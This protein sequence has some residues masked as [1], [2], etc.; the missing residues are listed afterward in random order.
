M[1]AA[2]AH[3]HA[4]AAKRAALAAAAVAVLLCFAPRIVS[5]QTAP[6]PG[7]RDQ[8]SLAEQSLPLRTALHHDPTLD[9][10]LQ[11]LV[12]LYRHRDRVDDLLALYAQ[13]LDRWPQDQA[14]RTVYLRLLLAT[15]DPSALATARQAVEAN[16]EHAFF[17]YLLY[18]AL[19]NGG[20]EG[21]LDH[22]DQ[23]IKLSDDPA[24]RQRWI[25]AFLPLAEAEGRTEQIKRHLKTLAAHAGDDPLAR[26]DAARSMMSLDQHE[27]A[28]ETLVAT[29]E[30]P[31]PAEASVELAM[32]TARAEAELGQ[33]QAAAARLDG[34]LER[35]SSDYWRR[36]QIVRQR[37]G[38]IETEAER[39]QMI[40][41]AEQRVANSPGDVSAVLSLVDMLAGFDRHRSA[42]ARLREAGERMPQS[43]ALEHATLELLDRMRNEPARVEFLKNRLERE[44]DRRSLRL[45]LARSLY[46][47]GRDKE[48]LE[49]VDRAVAGLDAGER[50][51]R[52]LQT[53][54]FLR[55]SALVEPSAALFQRAV[56]LRP[57][58]LDV[59]RELAE[60]HLAMDQRGEVG[61]LFAEAAAPEAAIENVLDLADFLI[62]QGFLAEARSLIEPRLD[63]LPTH[64]DLRLLMLRVHGELAA[65]G[66]GVDL[67][68]RSRQLTD[69]T[70]RYRRW[71]EAAVAFHGNFDTVATFLKNEGERLRERPADWGDAAVQ[72]RLAYV[73]VAK[74]NGQQPA[75]RRLLQA[76]LEQQ[77]PEAV[78]KRF[79]RELLTLL[80]DREDRAELQRLLAELAEQ[81]ASVRDEVNARLAVMHAQQNRLHLAQPLLQDIDPANIRDLSLLR[82]L[83][84]VCQRLGLDDQL[85]P[86]MERMVELN[87][88]SRP[89]WEQ[90]LEALAMR[91]DESRF[92]AA[93]R[94]LSMGI[95][96]MPLNTGTK[97]RLRMHLLSSY[98]RSIGRLEQ[99][100]DP[101]AWHE[102]LGLIASA[103]RIVHDPRELTWI[104]WMRAS[105]L[106]RLG[107]EDARDEAL[108]E[109]D[110][111]ARSAAGQDQQNPAAGGDTT[112]D[113]ASVGA[114]SEPSS[115]ID[116][117]F[118]DGMRVSLAEAKRVL[119]APF[120][121]TDAF[122]ADRQGPA[123]ASGE[124][125]QRWAFQ[126]PGVGITAV[127]RGV[128]DDL[129]L[130]DETGGLW[131]VDRVTGKLRWR[132]LEALPA[133]A[134][135]S[136]RQQSNI[137][138][139]AV[140]PLRAPGDRLVASD[141]KQIVC[142]SLPERG[143]VWRSPLAITA[144]DNNEAGGPVAL[145]I[146]GAAVLAYEAAADRL[147]WFDLDTGKLLDTL[148]LWED[149][150]PGTPPHN[151]SLQPRYAELQRH[152]DRLLVLGP[153]IAIVDLPSREVAWRFDP[154]GVARFPIQLKA[155]KD[156]DT[157]AAG[158]T[159]PASQ[160]SFAAP[161]ATARVTTSGM[162]LQRM[163]RHP[164]GVTV[165][166]SARAAGNAAVRYVDYHQSHQHSRSHHPSR[167]NAFVLSSPV[168]TW[169][170]QADSDHGATAALLADR[171]VLL[172]Q[173]GTI[174][175]SYRNPL[176][177][178]Q[179]NTG[180][181]LLGVSGSQ[182]VL[183]SA[184]H[185]HRFD[186]RTLV[187]RQASI[188]DLGP[189]HDGCID[190]PVT[191]AAG[192]NGVAA[193]NTVTGK[194]LWSHRWPGAGEGD[195]GPG[196]ANHASAQ[197]HQA[198]YL[199]TM[200]VRRDANTHQP[201]GVH[202]V[203]ARP[204]DGVLYVMRRPDELVAIE[205]V[206]R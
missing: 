94:K 111:I 163:Q 176:G 60:V 16:P 12:K 83:H 122:P 1:N 101:A 96:K 76:A 197:P 77:P 186:T 135:S 32:I 199:P 181:T 142:L 148:P 95:E 195:H 164:S 129:V 174:S 37:L 128:D 81:D 169:M 86:L 112:G 9:A 157:S 124:V 206:T 8:P 59:K 188:Q 170:Q 147:A 19:E 168:V 34:L 165:V 21:A 134:G 23:A 151:G 41:R 100:D 177:A 28:L 119:T 80:E 27:L 153:T 2:T 85:L 65:S 51:E 158:A 113:A 127:F 61:E 193:I 166:H 46:L 202:R 45:Q 178:Q 33:T 84:R 150:P 108:A 13:H 104:V 70:A 54:R 146:D 183:M 160:A 162:H 106:N 15:S 43:R 172:A 20:E 18:L 89:L 91:G 179:V 5:A 107:R 69:T 117:V 182:V 200:I 62:D 99:R 154:R 25:H 78:D 67:I 136:L 68:E 88:T 194:R 10:P 110:R 97:Q 72:R 109:L 31:M 71:L 74:S 44:P 185:L 204:M 143:L 40:E 205:E 152:G 4:F 90:W 203:V 79:R 155:P 24:M 175:W 82:D 144:A 115:A 189:L 132:E 63:Q 66:V 53:A 139:A 39:A 102:A 171:I 48:A 140:A 103:Q 14:A 3:G 75:G 184:H 138:A 35:V 114:S 38:L 50:F 173:H 7:D 49:Q 92:R 192:R 137:P 105:M 17:R 93:V 47:L 198:M 57:A 56:A 159:T 187:T 22:L 30:M 87:P 26:L 167:G 191:Y 64:L 58:R 116:I 73:E 29:A 196:S 98:W 6:A 55:E 120:S 156:Q 36:P 52:L 126:T 11:A 123:P 180:G 118:P 133:F 141:G 201:A 190:G 130:S 131:G 42:L 121:E 145:A 161:H 149:T 125:R